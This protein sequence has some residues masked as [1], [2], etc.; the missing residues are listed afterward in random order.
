MFG[1]RI[2]HTPPA[3]SISLGVYKN[4]AFYAFDGDMVVVWVCDLMDYDLLEINETAELEFKPNFKLSDLPLNEK[5]TICSLTSVQTKYGESIIVELERNVVFLPKRMVPLL[6]GKEAKF[7]NKEYCLVYEGSKEVG[8]LNPAQLFKIVKKDESLMKPKPST[9]NPAV[10]KLVGPSRPNPLTSNPSTSRPSTSKPSTFNP[11]VPKLVIAKKCI[12]KTDLKQDKYS[13]VSDTDFHNNSTMVELDTTVCEEEEIEKQQSTVA[14][15][16]KLEQF[17]SE[18]KDFV[19]IKQEKRL[20][21]Y[22]MLKKYQSKVNK[23]QKTLDILDSILMNLIELNKVS[24]VERKETIKISEL[25][26]NKPIKISKEK[27]VNTKYGDAV[28]LKL[29][30]K[31][32]FL[33]QRVTE[34]YRPHFDEFANQLYS[35]IYRREIAIEK[36][37]PLASFEIIKH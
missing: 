26:L 16:D 19:K 30:D 11:V 37:S 36:P 34:T 29:V 7:E 1:G 20:Q 10:P 8:K 33:S 15:L 23:I 21:L 18:T 31:A 9:S 4:K 32:I 25:P 35:I 12:S 27:I 17:I 6:K 5:F 13:D 3:D 2:Q 14:Y 22:K 28:L 24:L